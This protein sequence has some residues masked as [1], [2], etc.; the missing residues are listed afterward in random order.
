MQSL[1]NHGDHKK[2]QPETNMPIGMALGSCFGAD[3][4]VDLMSMFGIWL[5]VLGSSFD[6]LVDLA[7]SANIKDP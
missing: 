7:I 6:L 3:I 1:F 5:I 2:K 4:G